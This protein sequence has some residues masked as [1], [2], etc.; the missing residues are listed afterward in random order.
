[1]AIGE[2]Q[3]RLPYPVLC[4]LVGTNGSRMALSRWYLVECSSVRSSAPR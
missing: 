1:M 2:S 3:S 4:L